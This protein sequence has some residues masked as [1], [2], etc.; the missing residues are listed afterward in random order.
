MVSIFQVLFEISISISLSV[1]PYQTVQRVSSVQ[2]VRHLPCHWEDNPECIWF[3]FGHT[4]L[5]GSCFWTG[6][7]SL[8]DVGYER[9]V[10]NLLTEPWHSGKPWP[11]R[12]PGPTGGW[13]LH[14]FGR[15]NI[16]LNLSFLPP[17]N[18]EKAG[19]PPPRLRE[20]LG[21][22]V[23]RRG[24]L[25]WCEGLPTCRPPARSY[26]SLVPGPVLWGWEFSEGYRNT[27]SNTR[28]GFFLER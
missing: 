23:T 4:F 13:T 12:E 22:Y 19:T 11:L 26:P 9:S 14:F 5:S 1:L 25:H 17:K 20:R 24:W 18:F 8:K 27:S 3:C 7:Y 16:L 6:Q 15:G 2:A 28:L 10:D 21:S